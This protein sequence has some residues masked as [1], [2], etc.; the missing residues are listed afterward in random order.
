MK[1]LAIMTL[2]ASLSLCS[3]VATEEQ[4]HDDAQQESLIAKINNVT[5][6]EL[7]A[8]APIVHYRLLVNGK[9]E[10]KNR[11]YEGYSNHLFLAAVPGSSSPM[12]KG[13][14]IHMKIGKSNC[15]LSAPSFKMGPDNN[16]QSTIEY[17]PPSKNV[18]I[19]DWITIYSVKIVQLDKVARTVEV[20][21]KGAQQKTERD[22]Q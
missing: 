20:Q 4:K 22:S 6:L 3:C 8:D 21:I 11:I 9:T 13:A 14:Y 10:D 19:G 5:V 16:M 7:V 17:T 12:G 1:H 15:M 18:S 2:V